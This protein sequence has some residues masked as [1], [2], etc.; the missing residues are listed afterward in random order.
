M[1]NCALHT[2][3][4]PGAH[5]G[6]TCADS[7]RI[8]FVLVPPPLLAVCTGSPEASA[9]GSF[10]CGNSSAVG[11]VC[12][13]TCTI[14]GGPITAECQSTGNW[15]VQGTCNQD[16]PCKLTMCRPGKHHDRPTCACCSCP[17]VCLGL[18][19]T[20]LFS[21]NFAGW[22]THY[23]HGT[24]C[25]TCADVY[26]PTLCLRPC[27]QCAPA[28]PRLLQAAALTVVTSQLLALC[29]SALAAPEVDQ[30]PLSA[31]PQ[32]TGQCRAHATKSLTGRQVSGLGF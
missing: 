9:G 16:M 1:T 26:K 12:N 31:S 32:A 21:L 13:G 3:C 23:T 25:L 28:F 10:D 30:S 6:L 20:L 22:L 5:K 4:T 19:H 18:Q 29:A 17:C 27:L 15:T 8:C 14:G 2:T 24:T 11:T 7:V